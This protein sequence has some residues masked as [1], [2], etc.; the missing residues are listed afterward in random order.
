MARSSLLDPSHLPDRFESVEAL[1]EF[2]ARPSQALIDDLAQ[3]DGDLM[4]LGVAGKMGPTLARLARHATPGRRVIGVA[5]F[6]DT[7]LRDRLES[8]GVECIACDLLDRAALAR[9]PRAR[10]VVFAAGHKFGATGNQPLTWA[11]NTHVP[12]L[13]ADE[14]RDARF[15]VFSTGNVYPL[16]PVGRQGAT[17]ATPPEPVGEYA[18]S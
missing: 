12:A 8:W 4:I 14:F 17:E 18:Q 16:T 1:E 11:M 15:V 7:A 10:N 13:V 5:R 2:L 9:L 6:S 3:V